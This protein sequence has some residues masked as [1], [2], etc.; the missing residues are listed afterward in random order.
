MGL[1]EASQHLLDPK[2]D[3]Q[4]AIS[5]LAVLK[6]HLTNHAPH[7]LQGRRSN[8]KVGTD[9]SAVVS[10]VAPSSARRIHP[11]GDGFA[12]A[13]VNGYIIHAVR[14]HFDERSTNLTNCINLRSAAIGRAGSAT[15]CLLGIRTLHRPTGV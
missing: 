7:K 15:H 3:E 11:K 13:Q 10:F 1:P 9:I 6:K 4:V 12:I 2:T 14:P 5:Q 8:G